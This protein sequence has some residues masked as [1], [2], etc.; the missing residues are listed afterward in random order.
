MREAAQTRP[1]G[2]RRPNLRLRTLRIN[3]GLS[4]NALAARAGV[5]GNT[6]RMAEDGFLPSVRVQFALA[7]VF[8]LRPLDIWPLEDQ[9]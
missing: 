3:E 6:V 1:K 2:W 9:L 4:P 8:D 5:S 7:G